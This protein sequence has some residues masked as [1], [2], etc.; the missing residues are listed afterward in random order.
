MYSHN[1]I[2]QVA[3][4]HARELSGGF[5]A[6]LGEDFL[7]LIY[8]AINRD[9]DSVL[10]VELQDDTVVGFVSG[11]K[12]LSG[13]YLAI[14]RKPFSLMAALLKV[15]FIRSKL[16]GICEIV[17]ARSGVKSNHQQAVLP[18]H[19]LF[20]IAI[21]PDK[22]GTGTAEKLYRN[23]CDFFVSN[24]VTEFKIQVG[25]EL[26]QANRFYRRMGAEKKFEFEVHVGVKSYIYVQ[27][28]QN[29]NDDDVRRMAP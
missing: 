25:S 14:L 6:E 10:F 19:E 2:Q 12:G 24:N 13:V 23:L 11:G 22:R 18:S 5:L 1:V 15:L 28:L 26:L 20:S 9:L 27:T 16:I 8:D 4:L 29:N 17:F 7:F 3:K 21:I